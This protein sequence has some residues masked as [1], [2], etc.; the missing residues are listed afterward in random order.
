MDGGTPPQTPVDTTLVRIGFG[1][2]YNYP[3][4]AKHP[5]VSAQIFKYLPEALAYDLEIPVSNITMHSLQPLDTR[6]NLGYI[7]TVAYIFIPS[8]LVGKLSADLR[9]PNSRLYTNPDE[10]LYQLA[11]LIDSSFPLVDTNINGAYTGGDDNSW[12]DGG[13][14]G[15]DNGDDND[16]SD[17]GSLLGGTDDQGGSKVMAKSAGIA[18]GIVGGAAVYGAAMFFVARRYR[19]RRLRHGRVSS[20]SRSISPGNNPA[21]ALMSGAVMSGAIAEKRGSNGSG[22]RV[23]ARGQ[24]ISG[25]M[26]AEN[27]LGWN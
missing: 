17:G 7:K 25:P 10:T 13:D 9:S 2:G 6:Y 16:N 4:V 5:A 11:G 19:R 22:G 18:F 21:G 20:I 15:D 26:Q 24:T 12:I 27:S 23:S 8:D 1:P 14:K 3:F